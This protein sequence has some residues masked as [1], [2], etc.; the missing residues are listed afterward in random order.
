MNMNPIR[1][2]LADDHTLMRAGIGALLARMDG[3][4]VV[5]EAA[6]GQEALLL[7]R[8][9]R[10]NILLADIAMPLLNGIELTTRLSR[11]MPDVR[12]IILSGHAKEDFITRALEAG[13]RGYVLK[14]A[15]QAELEM[16]IRAVAG[17][18]M[19]LSPTVS[20][21]VVDEFLAR[22]RGGKAEREQGGGASPFHS[23]TSRQREILQL[24]AEGNS[25]KEVAQK[26]N[27]S[28]KTVEAHRT[29]IMERLN[30][31]DTAGLVRYAIRSGIASSE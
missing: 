8:K 27:L 2:I 28:V 31:H 7:V 18:G 11:E 25:N 6:D 5:G 23:L 15:Q 14:D 26:L 20:G 17:D 10:P 29:Q 9:K 16:A 21:K 4:S 19:Y 1:I 22:M 3:V 13:A 12:V 24:I 30:I